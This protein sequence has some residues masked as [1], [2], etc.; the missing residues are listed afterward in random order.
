MTPDAGARRR[1]ARARRP[2]AVRPAPGACR[3]STACRGRACAPSCGRSLFVHAAEVVAGA[4]VDL[5]LRARLEEERHLDLVAGLD[6]G[7]LRAAGRAVTL[8][9]RLGVRDL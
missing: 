2:A 5:D 7:G 1:D 8:Q 3:P 4:R 9:S 6:G